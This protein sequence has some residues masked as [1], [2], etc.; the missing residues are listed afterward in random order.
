MKSVEKCA[1]IRSDKSHPAR[2]AWIEI[3]SVLP[4]TSTAKSRTPQG[5]RG[6][7]LSGSWGHLHNDKS[8]PARGAWIEMLRSA[9]IPIAVL[10]APRKGCVD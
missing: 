2:G 4:F 5:V 10:V 6:L 7:K 1:C 3:F 8:H 9:I